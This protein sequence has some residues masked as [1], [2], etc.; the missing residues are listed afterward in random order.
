MKY[1]L[2]IALAFLACN[3][4][5]AQVFQPDDDVISDTTTGFLDPEIVRYKDSI[6]A[7]FMCLFFRRHTSQIPFRLQAEQLRVLPFFCQ[8]FFVAADFK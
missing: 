5:Q 6:F 4:A 1:I 2:F 7:P 8:Q 3:V